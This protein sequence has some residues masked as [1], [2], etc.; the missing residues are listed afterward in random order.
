MEVYMFERNIITELEQWASK[1]NH[2]PL[3]LRGSRQVGKTTLV[4]N[5]SLVAAVFD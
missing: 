3:I 1:Q 2:K 5:K 4:E